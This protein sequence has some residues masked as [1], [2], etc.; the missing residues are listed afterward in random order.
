MK[1]TPDKVA[2]LRQMK[3]EKSCDL[4]CSLHFGVSENCIAKARRRYGIPSVYGR[5]RSYTMRGGNIRNLLNNL[6][7][8]AFDAIKIA[9]DGGRP[10][11]E[12]MAE[13]INRAT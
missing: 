3:S 12:V 10:I 9:S 13:V 11:D 4:S 1:W 6:E 5:K 2:E 7:A 8:G